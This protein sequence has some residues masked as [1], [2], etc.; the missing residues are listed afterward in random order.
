MRVESC[1]LSVCDLSLGFGEGGKKQK[2]MSRPFGVSLLIAGVDQEGPA[3][4]VTT[5]ESL[6]VHGCSPAGVRT[7]FWI[8]C[9]SVYIC[10]GVVNQYFSYATQSIQLFFSDRRK[11]ALTFS[12]FEVVEPPTQRAQRAHT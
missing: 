8:H 3:L 4:Y 6:H 12:F 5:R 1:T 7:L 9:A 2:K 11:Y 10:R